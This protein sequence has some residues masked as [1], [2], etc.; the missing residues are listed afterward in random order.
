MYMK[1]R[2]LGGLLAL[3]LTA[4]LAGCGGMAEPRKE[5]SG[6]VSAPAIEPAPAADSQAPAAPSPTT[7]PSQP[8]KVVANPDTPV[9]S[10]ANPPPADSG[11]G[12]SAAP[13]PATEPAKAG[14][15]PANP[16][17]KTPA[18]PTAGSLAF[19]SMERGAYS[20][21]TVP[22][23]VLI[24]GEASW[25][26]HWQQHA[27]RVMPVPAAPAVDFSQSSIL[28]VYMGER[29]SGGY[30]IE[31]TGAELVN[32]V[33]KV[34]VRETRPAP[35]AMVTMALTQPYHMVRLPKL[36]EGTR[37]EIVR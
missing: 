10:P 35:D 30:S 26:S 33:L 13:P 29:N 3:T 20:G 6:T 11:Q 7:T 14:T 36:P 23:A 2:L 21:V 28:A 18:P 19:A 22:G 16:A 27:A 24:T 32:G 12:Q 4:A 31:V 15:I 37:V 8:A 17:V 5:S 1:H 34:T 9:S 25:K